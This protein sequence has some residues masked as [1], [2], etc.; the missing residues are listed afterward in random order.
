MAT[1][2]ALAPALLARARA[3]QVAQLYAGWH[4]T[5]ASMLLGAALLCFVL[6]GQASPAWMAAWVALIVAN[7]AWRGL[8]VRA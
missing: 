3:D 7:Q 4:R 1:P 6:W 5:T 2:A 8:L